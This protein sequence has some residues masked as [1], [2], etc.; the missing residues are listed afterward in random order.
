M[1]DPRRRKTQPGPVLEPRVIAVPCRARHLRFTLPAGAILLDAIA[2][3][4]GAGQSAVLHL[5]GGGF[6]PFHY[7][8]PSFPASPTHAAFYSEAMRPDGVTELE[9]ARVTYGIRD[10]APWLHCHG[11][12]TEADGRKSGGHV[13]PDDTTI[14][15]P[16]AAEAWLLD[17]AGFVARHDPETNFIL[18][19]PEAAEPSNQGSGRFIA[20]RLRPNQDFCETLA[21]WC[22][23]RGIAKATVRGGVA[24]TNGTIFD[25]GREYETFPTELFILSGE[26]GPSADIE[27]ATINAIGERASGTIR[28][29]ANPI[30]MTAELLMEIP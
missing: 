16:I 8:M 7:V 4:L 20:L 27:I 23:S 2:A 9:H 22:A 14:A 25:D 12:W 15:A 24:S 19:A 10:G 18:F 21:A 26:I 28:P 1:M 13:I 29:G 3:A 11:F 5:Q 30:L 6:G 17:G